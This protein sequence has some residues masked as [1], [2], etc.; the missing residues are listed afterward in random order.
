M[1]TLGDTRVELGVDDGDDDDDEDM[2]ESLEAFPPPVLDD[3]EFDE[4]EDEVEDD[5]E[6][7]P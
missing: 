1:T 6:F 2:F 4:D 5:A 3:F 7:W